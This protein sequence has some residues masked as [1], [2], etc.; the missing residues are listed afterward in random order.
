MRGRVDI[1][2]L[3]GVKITGPKGVVPNAMFGGRRARVMFAVL[4][5]EYPASIDQHDLADVLWPG[6]LPRTWRPALRSAFSHVRA[7]LAATGCPE[8]SVDASEGIARLHLP[9][10][11]EIDIARARDD[12]ATAAA[13]TDPAQAIVRPR[14]ALAVLG[15]PLLASESGP[16]V[17][18][19]RD[20][21]LQLRLVALHALSTA[22][23]A[24]G[25]TELAIAAATEAVRIQPFREPGHRALMVAHAA[26]GDRTD[27]LRAYARLRTLLVEE[28]GLD[29]SPETEALYVDLLRAGGHTRLPA[30]RVAGV[31]P[32]RRPVGLESE[33]DAL[34]D[35]WAAM[36]RGGRPVLALGGTLGAGK[37]TL[38][39]GLASA[40]AADGT[41]V[42]WIKGANAAGIDQ[43]EQGTET[44]S[45]RL[46]AVVDDADRIGGPIS[47]GAR[48]RHG[49]T[50]TSARPAADPP[51]G[52]VD[53][54]RSARRAV[55][56][57]G[58]HRSTRPPRGRTAHHTPDHRDRSRDLGCARRHG[59]APPRRVR[60]RRSRGQPGIRCGV[61]PRSARGGF[62]PEASVDLDQLAVPPTVK[63]LA[64]RWLRGMSNEHIDVL[65]VAALLGSRFPLDPLAAQNPVVAL[66]AVERAIARGLLTSATHD[67]HYRFVHPIM[68]R[69][70]REQLTDLRRQRLIAELASADSWSHGHSTVP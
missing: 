20:E 41:A 24:T 29:P 50:R 5:W 35:W 16:W 25:E 13:P 63:D 54:R 45:P 64:G 17:E 42:L 30:L 6:S 33:A 70:L 36:D 1:Q 15:G 46:L 53:D 27:A 49:S 60:C 69:I 14:A 58:R 62:R 52:A 21:L 26:N 8:T 51:H 22:L 47:R 68:A 34:A 65:T 61:A 39:A 18:R 55:R 12:V 56:R 57:S 9:P 32:A 43:L 40:A 11:V 37:T 4:A 19:R 28:M 44:S 2:L 66:D 59:P 31:D 3:G 48:H 38:A 7:T 10:N 23:V 67:G